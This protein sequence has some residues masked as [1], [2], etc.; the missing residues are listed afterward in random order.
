MN[1]KIKIVIADDHPMII[2]GIELMLENEETYAVVGSANSIREL[3]S[4]IREQKPDL[5]LLDLNIAGENILDHI[6]DLKTR[7]PKV[8]TLIISSYDANTFVKIAK[9]KGVDGYILKNTN[10]AQFLEV[11]EKIMAGAFYFINTSQKSSSKIKLDSLPEKFKDDFLKKGILSERE[12]EIIK[13][14]ANGN[15]EQEIADALFLSKHTIHTHRKNIMRK[16]NIHSA[17]ELVRFAYE[18]RLL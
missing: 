8:K 12:I 7:F 17:V 14:I 1:Q 6:E 2:D 4:V 18:S 15:T 5:T 9:E 3:F 11:L 10:K 13:Y 16:L